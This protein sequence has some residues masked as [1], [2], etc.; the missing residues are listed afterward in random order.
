[1]IKSFRSHKCR[2]CP[3]L[4]YSHHLLIQPCF[5]S[6]GAPSIRSSQHSRLDNLM[7][8][9]FGMVRRHLGNHCCPTLKTAEKHCG[10]TCTNI[11]NNFNGVVGAPNL[12]LYET[13]HVWNLH[14]SLDPSLSQRAVMWTYLEKWF[15]T[16]LISSE[17]LMSVEDILF[18]R[19]PNAFRICTWH[20][21]SS[22]K[23][24]ARCS[25]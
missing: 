10:M 23:R 17:I 25:K 24:C 6:A 3:G 20:T 11:G 1:M 2:D 13:I 21:H 7:P 4:E 15:D 5:S 16:E 18:H 8:R 22:V 12:N 19:S 9:P 14:I